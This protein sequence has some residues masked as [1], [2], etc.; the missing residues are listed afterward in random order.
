VITA[1]DALGRLRRRMAQRSQA[2]FRKRQGTDPLHVSLHKRRIYIL[3]TK[4]GMMYAA[5]TF[6]LLMGSLNYANNMGFLLTF[7]LTAVGLIAMHHCHRNLA[8][9]EVS[10]ADCEPVFAGQDAVVEFIIHSAHN[11]WQLELGWDNEI[12]TVTDTRGA[13]D[14]EPRIKVRLPMPTEERGWIPC[15]RI[16]V[17]TTYPLG[18]FRAWAWIYMDLHALVYPKPAD[19]A[20]PLSAADSDRPANGQR[21]VGDD[22]FSELREYRRGDSIKHVAWK[23]VASLGTMLVKDYR[24]GGQTPRWIDWNETPAADTEARLAAMCRLALTADQ[25]QAIYGLRMPDTILAPSR[26]KQHLHHCLRE[27]AVFNKSNRSPNG[28]AD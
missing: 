2:F 26:G 17:S 21:G 27:L 28:A 3:P 24:E 12:I 22:E 4:A 20:P 15:P 11:R 18:L 7:L 19:T 25:Q 8:D 10:F 13:A 14:G 1:R 9:L 6:L 5:V 16:G 23:S